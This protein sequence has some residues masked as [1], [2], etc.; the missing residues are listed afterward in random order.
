MASE[1]PCPPGLGVG[2][3]PTKPATILGLLLIPL[4]YSSAPNSELHR[5]AEKGA[6]GRVSGLHRKSSMFNIQVRSDIKCPDF[7]AEKGKRSR[8]KPSGSQSV[9]SRHLH[10]QPPCTELCSVLL[11]PW[12]SPWSCTFMPVLQKAKCRTKHGGKE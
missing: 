4:S 8:R 10:V 9:L 1:R 12:P 7:Q 11:L 5:P 2:A 3:V 6:R